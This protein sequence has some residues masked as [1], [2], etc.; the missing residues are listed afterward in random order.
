[1]KKSAWF[2]LHRV[3][4]AMQDEDAATRKLFGEIEIDESFIGGTA[5][6]MHK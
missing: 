6:N 5:R 1:M 2:L 3:R 4:L